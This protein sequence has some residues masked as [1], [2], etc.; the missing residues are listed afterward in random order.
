MQ[1]GPFC[2][3]ICPKWTFSIPVA[4]LKDIH[5]PSENRSLQ[6]SWTNNM[7]WCWSLEKG[8]GCLSPFRTEIGQMTRCHQFS[9]FHLQVQSS[10]F[11]VDIP[12]AWWFSHVQEGG[13][14][15]PNRLVGWPPSPSLID[16]L[17]WRN[18]WF[19]LNEF[20]IT[21]A[22]VTT[23]LSITFSFATKIPTSI[24][25]SW[26]MKSHTTYTNMSDL[27]PKSLLANHWFSSICM[28]FNFLVSANEDGP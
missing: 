11:F 3:M 16:R 6:K 5:R 8:D 24:L 15:L 13:W 2:S 14:K 19:P 4:I 17:T 18:E 23:N 10:N 12:M 28:Y 25:I 22:G 7:S 27:Q 21:C 1:T 26:Y 9:A 20:K